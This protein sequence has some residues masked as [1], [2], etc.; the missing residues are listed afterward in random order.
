MSTRTD[1]NPYYCAED[2][3]DIFGAGFHQCGNKRKPD[4]EFCGTHSPEAAARR[5]AKSD[6]HWEAMSKRLNAPSKELARLRAVN[7]K[8]LEALNVAP[9]SCTI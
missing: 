2:V 8:L 9:R 4:S 7:A 5:R 3:H 6:A 1:A